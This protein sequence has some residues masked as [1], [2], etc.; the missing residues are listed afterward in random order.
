MTRR[1]WPKVSVIVPV[2]N[3]ADHL[4]EAVS[5]ILAQ[6][7][8]GEMEVVL[9]IAPSEDRTEKVATDLA[10]RDPRL[11]VVENPQST[12]PAG[13]NRAIEAADGEVIVRVDGHSELSERYVATAVEILEETGAWNVGGIQ[14]AV[15]DTPMQS[16]IAAAMGSRFGTGDAHFHYGGD[17]GPTDTVY[18]GVWP[19]RVLQELGGFNESLI[20]NQD[21]E[22]NVRIRQAGGT[23]WFDPRLEVTYRPRSSLRALASQY[24]QYGRWKR[25]M[26]R[27]HP[28]SLRWR[29]TVPPAALLANLLGLGLGLLHPWTLAVPCAYL[30]GTFA[31]TVIVSRGSPGLLLRLPAVFATMHHAWGAGFL[32][33]PS[34]I[35]ERPRSP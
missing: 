33:G 17:P 6:G 25:A 22:L 16:A 30:V 20:R 32:V 29:Q 24:W 14:R 27:Q 26:L 19:R 13:L 4:T 34:R 18:L 31:A 21:Y 8:P 1:D 12:T 2:R 10:G 35:T 28:D 15:G 3:E 7:Y 5:S 9:A 11:V 23:V